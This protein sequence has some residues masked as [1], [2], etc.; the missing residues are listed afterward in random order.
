[1]LTVT[2]LVHVYKTYLTA[3]VDWDI[4]TVKIIH[5]KHFRGAKFLRFCM[6][7]FYSRW[8]QYGRVPGAFLAGIR[9]V[10]LP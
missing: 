2:T 4:S 5:I 8:L 9:R 1:M 3:T 7:S 6:S 10:G